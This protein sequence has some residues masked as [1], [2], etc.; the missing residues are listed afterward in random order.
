MDIIQS[1][2][3]HDA[4]SK[5]KI[6]LDQLREGLSA[7]GFLKK[8]EEYKPLFKPL[9]VK[10]DG[11]VSG[12]EVVNILNFPS[13]MEGNETHNFLKAILHNASQEMIC[14]FLTFTTGA[15]CLPDFGL[16][17]IDVKFDHVASI[18]ASACTNSITLPRGFTDEVTFS[19][20]MEA[21]L[22]TPTK[23]FTNV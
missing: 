15:P 22:I 11:N 17:K 14:K 1:I 12:K 13:S 4:I 18:Y 6:L 20:L 23:S 9:F 7:L 8:M 2:I 10:D 5:P 3:V 19:A 21:V 16:G